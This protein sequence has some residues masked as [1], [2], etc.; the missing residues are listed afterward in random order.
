MK[1]FKYLSYVL[2]HKWF[3]MIECFKEGLYWRG[4][5]HDLSKFLPREFIPYMNYFY[6]KGSDITKGRNKTGYYKPT[7]TGDKAFDFAW[8]LHQKRNRHHW[9][10]WI[11]PEDEGGV[12]ILEIQEP[13]FTEMICDWIGAGK[14]QGYFS[15]KNDKYFET[16][17]WW[18]EN[19]H[20]MQLNPK[21]R[22]KLEQ[23]LK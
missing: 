20:K 19:N 7:D 12:K 16:R 5:T 17:K 22:G 15:P 10:W 23:I 14:A 11:L 8:L 18:K 13:Y 1:F 21:T 4:I 3:V 9:Q 2:R 6:G